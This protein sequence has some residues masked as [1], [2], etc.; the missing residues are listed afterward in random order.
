MQRLGWVIL[1]GRRPSATAR[2][3][4]RTP[5]RA[6]AHNSVDRSGRS[7]RVATGRLDRLEAAIARGVEAAGRRGRWF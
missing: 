5:C 3:N 6:S 4:A 2:Q 1:G 7:A